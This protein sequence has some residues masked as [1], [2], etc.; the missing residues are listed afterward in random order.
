MKRRK[1]PASPGKPTSSSSWT[2]AIFTS[3]PRRIRENKDQSPELSLTQRSVFS[4]YS[5]S[6]NTEQST[7]TTTNENNDNNIETNNTETNNTEP[8]QLNISKGIMISM[9]QEKPKIRI[10]PK[11]HYF[12]KD[13]AISPASTPINDD[14]ED[15]K[16][17]QSETK[18]IKVSK[19]K[20]HELFCTKCRSCCC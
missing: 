19:K 14:T 8:G 11:A 1:S 16:F 12:V 10:D 17:S 7:Q 9:I 2:R 5:D 15:D 6:N 18:I 13:L 20:E 3:Q 4:I